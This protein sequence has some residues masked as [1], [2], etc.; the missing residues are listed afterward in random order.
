[1]YVGSNPIIPFDKVIFIYN[2]GEYPVIGSGADCKS[3]VFGFWRFKSV[4]SNLINIVV[5]PSGKAQDFD[6]CI[7][8]LESN[9]HNSI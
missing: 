4:F 9:Y 2:F 7:R 5:L 6:S 8:W 3:V 1:M